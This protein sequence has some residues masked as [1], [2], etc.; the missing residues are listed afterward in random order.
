MRA[1]E[2]FLGSI[3]LEG[4]GTLTQNSYKLFRTS[5]K[6]YCEGE[7]KKPYRLDG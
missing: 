2:Y 1:R 7:E 4:A 3:F 6:I 5:E